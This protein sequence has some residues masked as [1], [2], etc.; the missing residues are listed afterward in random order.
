M[1]A[2]SE[3]M[4]YGFFVRFTLNSALEFTLTDLRK[5]NENENKNVRKGRSSSGKIVICSTHINRFI[6]NENCNSK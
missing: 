4:L 5:Q 2:L 3:D 1:E 6:V